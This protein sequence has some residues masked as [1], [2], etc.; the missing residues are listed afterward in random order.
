M[1]LL[2]K[3]SPASAELARKLH[4]VAIRRFSVTGSWRGR[5]RSL[6]LLLAFL[7]R[8][9]FYGSGRYTELLGQVNRESLLKDFWNATKAS[10]E[11]QA[12]QTEQG[13][14]GGASSGAG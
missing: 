5:M 4:L 13:V 1:I 9:G 3:R 10:T 6:V 7:A 2:R 12:A 14:P 8:P 11:A